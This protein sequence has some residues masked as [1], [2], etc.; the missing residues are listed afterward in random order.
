MLHLVG[1]VLPVCKETFYDFD[2]CLADM[3]TRI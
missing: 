1:N 2:N 3:I